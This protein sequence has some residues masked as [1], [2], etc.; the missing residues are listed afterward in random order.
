MAPINYFL[1]VP[2]RYILVEKGKGCNLE[3]E[4]P[5]YGKKKVLIKSKERGH[6][7][8]YNSTLPNGTGKPGIFPE[9]YVLR[10]SV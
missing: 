6:W 9:I 5:Y 2:A 8:L 1:P 7:P 3:G 10:L 4:M